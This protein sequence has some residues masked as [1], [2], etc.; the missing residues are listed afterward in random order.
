M[1]GITVVGLC[2]SFFAYAE[3][4]LA[5]D[6]M[7]VGLSEPTETVV[8]VPRE[9]KERLDGK[10][11]GD[12]LYCYYD[13]KLFSLGATFKDKVCALAEIKTDKPFSTRVMA[14]WIKEKN[15]AR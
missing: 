8:L 9:Q 14:Q 12:A 6:T 15:A 13:G 3:N 7:P 4:A 1:K 5:F 2:A 11:K 10:D